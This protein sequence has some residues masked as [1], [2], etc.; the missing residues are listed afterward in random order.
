MSHFIFTINIYFINNHA[1][2][3]T[4]TPKAATA[5]AASEASFKSKNLN[6]STAAMLN[7][8]QRKCAHC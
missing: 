2:I 4:Q 7:N 5:A 8:I 3:S 6:I 1:T